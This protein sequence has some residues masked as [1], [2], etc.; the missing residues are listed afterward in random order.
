MFSV[1]QEFREGTVRTNC[2]CFVMF[3]SSAEMMEDWGVIS[4]MGLKYF[5]GF[6]TSRLVFDV[7]CQSGPLLGCSL[8]HL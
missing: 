2:F 3:G 7:I 4:A 8:E 6:F 5:E 1:G